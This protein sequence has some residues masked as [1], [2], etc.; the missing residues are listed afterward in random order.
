LVEFK[1]LL[2]DSSGKFQWQS[3]P[4]RSLQTGG[5]AKTLV[6]YED[7][8]DEKNQ[9]VVKEGDA[10]VQMAELVATDDDKSINDVVSANELQVD[11][12][13]EIKEDESSI[14]DDVNSTVAV[15]SSLQGESVKACEADLPEVMV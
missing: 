10:S 12:N 9:K 7:W 5:T 4:N 8:G 2:R 13:Q 11:V 14:G 1:F 6:V 15:I 3:G